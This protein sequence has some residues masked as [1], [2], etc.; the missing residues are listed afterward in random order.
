VPAYDPSL[1]MWADGAEKRRFI[2]LPPGTTI[3]TSDMDH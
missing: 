3:D 2:R 1:S